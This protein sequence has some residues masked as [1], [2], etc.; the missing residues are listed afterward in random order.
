M[1]DFYYVHL[2]QSLYGDLYSFPWM[3]LYLWCSAH[4]NPPS[5]P[6]KNL[7]TKKMKSF[8]GLPIEHEFFAEFHKYTKTI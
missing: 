2:Y 3:K 8:C 7:A 4:A 5:P 1:R 6:F